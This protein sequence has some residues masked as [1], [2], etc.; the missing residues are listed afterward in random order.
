MA[1]TDKVVKS[2]D[3]VDAG[4]LLKAIVSNPLLVILFTLAGGFGGQSLFGVS[5]EALEAK[6]LVMQSKQDQ[7][8]ENQKDAKVEIEQIKQRLTRLEAQGGR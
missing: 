7:V 2:Q 5:R 8:L 3:K 6:F 4:A 1:D